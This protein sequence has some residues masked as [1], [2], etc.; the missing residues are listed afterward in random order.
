MLITATAI[1][2]IFL[3]FQCSPA[4]SAGADLLP[5]E[6]TVLINQAMN[7]QPDS[8]RTSL[9][10]PL[11][12]RMKTT[13][14]AEIEF[15][16]KGEAHFLNL[17]PEESR[18]VF[19]EFRKRTDDIGRVAAQ[20]LMIIRINAF[21]MVDEVVGKD[22]PAYRQRFEDR[23]DDRYGIT[24]PVTRTAL[25]LVEMDK[26]DSALDLIAEEVSRHDK[27]DSPYTAYQLP[28]RFLALA[29]EHGRGEEFRQLLE[30]VANGL[31]D[32][33]KRRLESVTDSP[34][35]GTEM[36]GV[37]FRSLFEDQGFDYYDW[38]AAFLRLRAEIAAPPG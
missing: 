28:G 5:S 2:T 19:W 38:T 35:S 15:F 21:A 26:V 37:V 27:F 18:D 20:R 33:I 7:T 29:E 31:D 22:I 36:P 30:W 32:T 8:G 34:Q 9:T 16:L 17:E 24:F 1:L 3:A 13:D 6:T 12:S 4:R 10:R 14:L 25:R 23:P 11:I